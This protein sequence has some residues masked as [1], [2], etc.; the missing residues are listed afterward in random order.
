MICVDP[1]RKTQHKGIF[2]QACHLFANDND[3]DALHAF[4]KLIG[5]KRSWFQNSP[6]YPHYDLTPAKRQ[7]AVKNGAVEADRRYFTQLKG[8]KL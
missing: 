5:L 1:L 3:M 6:A 2:K 8:N 7:L 4:A